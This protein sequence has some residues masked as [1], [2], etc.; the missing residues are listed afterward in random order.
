MRKLLPALALV[1]GVWLVYMGYER[2][3]SLAGRTESEISALGRRLDGADHTPTHTR[4]YL[5]GALLA[6]GGAFGLGLFRK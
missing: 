3:Q 5:A 1:A 6:L 4:Y 2:Q